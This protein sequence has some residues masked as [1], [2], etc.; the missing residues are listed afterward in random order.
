MVPR[1]TIEILVPVDDA[2]EPVIIDAIGFEG[3]ACSIATAA[4][5]TEMGSVKNRKLKPE[6]NK[7]SATKRNIK[8]GTSQD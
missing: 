8:L 5:E 4:F 1:E 7:K 2:D 3:D 6:Y